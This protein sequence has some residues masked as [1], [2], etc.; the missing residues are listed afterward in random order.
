MWKTNKK[1]I[2]D[3]FWKNIKDLIQFII[4]MQVFRIF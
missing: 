3:E 4:V 1:T 2:T